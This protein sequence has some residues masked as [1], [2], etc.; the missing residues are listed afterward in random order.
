MH[1]PTVLELNGKKTEFPL[2]EPGL[3]L[4]FTNSTGLRY[5]AEEVRRCLLKGD[6]LLNL[7][8]LWWNEHELCVRMMLI[9]SVSQDWRRASRCHSQTQSCSLRSWMRPGDRWAW[10]MIR[11]ANDGPAFLDWP[12]LDGATHDAKKQSCLNEMSWRQIV[13]NKSDTN[14]AECVESLH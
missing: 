14:T 7:L 10:F 11:T 4:N 2:P 3:P 1:C 6:A 9:W 5:E 12:A 13:C 8:C